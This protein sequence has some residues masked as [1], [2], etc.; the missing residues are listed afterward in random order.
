MKNKSDITS[1][2][3][4]GSILVF[5]PV[6]MLVYAIVSYFIYFNA[7]SDMVNR[8]LAQQEKSLSEITLETLK[9]RVNSLNKFV[10]NSNKNETLDFLKNIVLKDKKPIIILNRNNKIIYKSSV[11]IHKDILNKLDKMGDIYTDNKI[12]AVS[13][14]NSKYGWK[15]VS[16]TKKRDYLNDLNLEKANIK[17]TTKDL[18]KRIMF[19]LLF[20]W[21]GLLVIS[22][23]ISMK[24]FAKLKRYEAVIKKTNE[25]VIF[26]S[27]QAMIGEL[28][29][30]IA[31]QWR[32][33]INKIAS[34]LMR[35][36]FEFAGG[37][38]NI[39]T[40]DRQ[41]QQIEDSVELMSNTID[42][43]RTFYRPKEEPEV[44]DVSLYVR[45][46]IYFLDELLARKKIQ[47]KT[48]LAQAEVKLHANEFLQVIIN[49]I[50]NASDAV[51]V[52]GTIYATVRE[53]NNNIVEIRIEDDGTGIPHD[54]LEKIFEPH[55]STKQGSM[56]L[57]LYMSKL[58]VESHLGGIIRAYN[59]SKGAGF[60]IRLPK[61]IDN[62]EQE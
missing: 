53:M 24:V 37:N 10:S 52:K 27:R 40:L 13:V 4:V 5:P 55:E 30:M 33:P 28:L 31:H 43:F 39:D 49:L 36:R 18:V 35:M 21:F 34:V 26:Q 23:T 12:I 1:K 44:V 6:I 46:A 59:T 7:Q 45:K 48:D 20:S 15:I 42:D 19:L 56:G 50:K 17:N 38:V 51:D 25:N 47:I 61:N 32:Q 58:I 60:L 41:A 3:I 22:I 57:G 54:K 9:T 29:P 8:I 14:K 2:R 11:N 16:F 62:K